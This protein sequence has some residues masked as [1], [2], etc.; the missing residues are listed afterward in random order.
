M[1]DDS[2]HH[3]NFTLERIY[4]QSKAEVWSAWSMREKKSA[5]LGNPALEMDFRVGGFERATYREETREHLNE[6]RYFEIKEGERIVLAYS[7]AVNG[8]VHTVSLA[9]ITFAVVGDGTRLR[10]HEQMCIIPPSDGLKGR[11][12]GWNLLLDALGTALAAH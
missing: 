8:R 7:M 4:P 9:T 5:W 11:Q 6:T 10:Y 1:A 2:Q 12:H 3:E